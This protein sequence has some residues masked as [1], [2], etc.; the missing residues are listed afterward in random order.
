MVLFENIKGADELLVGLR[1]KCK[2]G[3][4]LAM[5][6]SSES[7]IARAVEEA[8]K[9]RLL[10]IF[11]AMISAPDYGFS[12]TFKGRVVWGFISGN[13]ARVFLTE[14]REIID[15]K[16]LPSSA[17]DFLD[18]YDSAQEHIGTCFSFEKRYKTSPEA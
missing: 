10:T 12:D 6:N 15:E 2:L 5:L 7:A 16:L 13:G 9:A 4:E 3:R 17:I 11:G 1:I 8:L 18:L 14:N